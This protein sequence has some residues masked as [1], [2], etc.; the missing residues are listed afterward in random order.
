MVEEQWPELTARMR[1]KRDGTGRVFKDERSLQVH[2]TI[3][4][5][6]LRPYKEHS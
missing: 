5:I 2:I 1:T 3:K 4:A 6:E